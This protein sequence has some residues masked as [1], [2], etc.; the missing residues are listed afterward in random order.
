VRDRLENFTEIQ[1][2]D[3]IEAYTLEAVA[4]KLS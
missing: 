1:A 4:Q 3:I 2:G